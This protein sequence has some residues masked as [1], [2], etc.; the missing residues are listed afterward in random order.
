M[1]K[2]ISDL[3]ALKFRFEFAC[4]LMKR[5]ESFYTSYFSRK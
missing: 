3:E 2:R 4:L 1:C 5:G